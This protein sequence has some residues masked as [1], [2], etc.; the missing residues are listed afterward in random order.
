MRWDRLYLREL[1][2]LSEIP[3][4]DLLADNDRIASAKYHFVIAIEACID[5]AN[6]IVSSERYRIPRDNG[7]S[8]IVLVENGVLPEEKR[9]D[10][11]AMAR[12]R[13]RL[14]HLYWD[15]DDPLVHEYLQ[16]RL[17]DFQ[18]FVENVAG[19]LSGVEDGT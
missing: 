11:V 9:G 10:Y 4:E 18:A 12:F 5:I 13:N 8:F 7:D 3:R 14:V 6:H 1:R 15:V 17:G 2:R 16:T 19:F